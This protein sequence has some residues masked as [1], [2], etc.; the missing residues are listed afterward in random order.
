MSFLGCV[1]GGIILY[2]LL[3]LFAVLLLLFIERTI[4]TEAQR[5]GVTSGLN[6]HRELNQIRFLSI[7]SHSFHYVIHTSSIIPILTLMAL[8]DSVSSQFVLFYYF[9]GCTR[10]QLWHLG[11]QN[12]LQLM[13]PQEPHVGSSSLTRDRTQAH[14]K[15]CRGLATGP[16]GK[17][18]VSC[19][20]MGT[21]SSSG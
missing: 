20:R 3:K 10:S 17:S 21:R 9:I 2:L 8:L 16:S 19:L 15:K 6:S 18:K 5:S 11:S 1:L 13:N 14:C 7:Q 4:I 12:L